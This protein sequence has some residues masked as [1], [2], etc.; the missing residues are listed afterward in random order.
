MCWANGQAALSPTDVSH[1]TATSICSS[2]TYKIS[3]QQ[4]ELAAAG[5]DSSVLSPFT[6]TLSE[7]NEHDNEFVPSA[8]TPL[9]PFS[10]EYHQAL[11][12]ALALNSPKYA[13]VDQGILHKF[14][15]LLRKYP[16]AFLLSGSPLGEIHDFE[17]HVDTEDA[18]PVYKHPYHKKS[19]RASCY[20]E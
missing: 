8:T 4:K 11:I 7:F 19:R 15:Q 3:E 6:E 14:E 13:H 20:Q 16:T 1:P 18:L 12:K 2:Q 9:E 5:P 10:E 17:H